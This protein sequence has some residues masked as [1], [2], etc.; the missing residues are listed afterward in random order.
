MK[1]V[2]TP[3]HFERARAKLDA[4][5]ERIKTD[6]D[7]LAA[8]ERDVGKFAA[9]FEPDTPEVI[10][11]AKDV[12]PKNR[13]PVSR[14]VKAAQHNHP[15]LPDQ[16]ERLRAASR[17]DLVKLAEEWGRT[18]AGLEKK[19]EEI[20]G[21]IRR[22]PIAKPDAEPTP[23]E[24]LA[25][26]EKAPVFEDVSVADSSEELV[27]KAIQNQGWNPSGRRLVRPGIPVD[28]PVDSGPL[29]RRIYDERAHASKWERI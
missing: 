11:P 2:L 5:E 23:P 19:R 28:G 3:E 29:R 10:S 26:Q 17:E 13:P 8:L 27:G 7:K 24:P 16:I 25:P 22:D 9:S 12:K 15:Y 14:Q 20:L 21:P 1:F 6:R 18:F 4:A